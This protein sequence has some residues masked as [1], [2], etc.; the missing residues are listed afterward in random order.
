[1]FAVRL[2]QLVGGAIRGW[3]IRAA[4][5]LGITRPTLDRYLRYE[6]EGRLSAIPEAILA[7]VGI[8]ADGEAATAPPRHEAGGSPYDMVNLLAAGLC[9]LQEHVDQHGHIQA[10]YPEALLRGFNLAAALNIERGTSYPVDLASLVRNAM[11][12]IFEWCPEYGDGQ[13]SES[14]FASLLIEAGAVTPDC[15]SMA[16]LAEADAEEMFYQRLIAACSEID[17]AHGQAFYSEWRRAV[18]ENPVAE[19]HAVFLVRYETLRAWTSMTRQ[20][21]DFFYERIPEIHAEDGKIAL[22]P[23]SGTRLRKNRN[24]WATEMRDPAAEKMLRERGPRYI[25]HTPAT[26]ELKRPVRVFWALPGWHELRL[27]EAVMERGWKSLLWP[28]F[29]KYDL[30]V[31]R[32][33][34]TRF[35]IDV[36]D[37]LSPLSLARS[38]GNVERRRRQK[39]VLVIPDY[40]RERL[41]LYKTVFRRARRSALM[42]PEVIMT[43]SEFLDVLEGQE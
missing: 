35:A 25:D 27:H 9:R 6:A 28:E 15:I 41:P 43:V 20:L 34:K 18:I 8:H 30:L 5:F 33:G 37:H 11:S 36:K 10:P 24:R 16:G 21:V 26:L 32:P 23:L 4:A 14:F 2:Q 38:L 40:L 1:M 42:E 39:R 3:K 17:E 12:P 22:C 19:S 13:E 7:K 31:S 29:D